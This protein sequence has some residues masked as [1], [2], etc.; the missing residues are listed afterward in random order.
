MLSVVYCKLYQTTTLMIQA[1]FIQ[2]QREIYTIKSMRVIPE[3]TY[4]KID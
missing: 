4:L 1:F 2:K 3:K